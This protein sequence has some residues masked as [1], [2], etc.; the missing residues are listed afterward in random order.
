MRHTRIAAFMFVASSCTAAGAQA[1]PVSAP[2]SIFPG[3]KP[4]A[5]TRLAELRG[6]FRGHDFGLDMRFSMDMTQQTYINGAPA[7]DT[8][9][10]SN[11]NNVLKVIQNGPNNT[12]DITSMDLP[13]SS[14]TTIV[15][16]S[17]DNQTIST[18]NT[19][20]ISI[21]S[22]TISRQLALH[23]YLHQVLDKRY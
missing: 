13:T 18:L 6:G 8:I 12:L 23:S 21:A 11:H 16:N 20:N 17:K 4:V 14:V 3:L 10:I 2:S 9:D 7:P 22:Q 19:L 1:A 5:A 15:Q